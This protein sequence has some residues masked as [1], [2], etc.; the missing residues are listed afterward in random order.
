VQYLSNSDVYSSGIM[1]VVGVW[2]TS[3]RCMQ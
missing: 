1:H 2:T 3:D